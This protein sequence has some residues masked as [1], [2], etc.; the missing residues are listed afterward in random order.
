LEQD[1]LAGVAPRVSRFVG[2]TG[3]IIAGL[4]AVLFIAD[5][6]VGFP[7]R[8]VSIAV[9]L[10]FLVASLLL[11]YMSWSILDRRRR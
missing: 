7:F 5:L 4:V 2:L 1:A 11:A 9:D 10:G 3:L 6:A 8:R